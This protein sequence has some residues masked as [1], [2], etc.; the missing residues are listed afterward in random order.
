[1]KAPP[2][3]YTILMASTAVFTNPSLYDILEVHGYLHIKI[4][5]TT[6]LWT[7]AK[8]RPAKCL[9]PK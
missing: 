7:R 8:N 9:P 1:V 2:D 5:G 3:G 6:V 4:V